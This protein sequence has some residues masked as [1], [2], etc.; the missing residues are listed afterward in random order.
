MLVVVVVVVVVAFFG[1]WL[2]PHIDNRSQPQAR[3]QTPI[4]NYNHNHNHNYNHN[5]HWFQITVISYM[6]NGGNIC[7]SLN[8]FICVNHMIDWLLHN[9]RMHTVDTHTA[10]ENN[11]TISTHCSCDHYEDNKV[12]LI[13]LLMPKNKLLFKLVSLSVWIGCGW[14]CGWPSHTTSTTNLHKHH[15]HKP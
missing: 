11:V 4:H 6:M 12:M 3:P 1:K 9:V 14:C 10:C 8:T 2:K 15:Q 5:Q 7:L 13:W